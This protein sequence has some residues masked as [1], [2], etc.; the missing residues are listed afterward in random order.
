[1]ARKHCFSTSR[2]TPLTSFWIDYLCFYSQNRDE[3]KEPK[4]QRFITKSSHWKLRLK[5]VSV[6]ISGV[7]LTNKVKQS[8]SLPKTKVAQTVFQKLVF[9]E[10]LLIR[11]KDTAMS[12]SCATMNLVIKCYNNYKTQIKCESIQYVSMR[13]CLRLW[14][15]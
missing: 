6:E 7:H 1:M 9:S 13:L 11:P 4:N 15:P 8:N 3:L 12:M 5:K 10:P 2:N 14:K